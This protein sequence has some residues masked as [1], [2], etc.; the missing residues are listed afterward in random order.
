M[1]KTS[2]LMKYFNDYLLINIDHFFKIHKPTPLINFNLPQFLLPLPAYS[3]PHV[4]IS[5]RGSICNG[6][7]RST[8]LVAK[9][10]IYPA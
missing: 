3:N 6:P 1:T 4:N 8:P 7:S 10:A 5:D 2:N 9:H